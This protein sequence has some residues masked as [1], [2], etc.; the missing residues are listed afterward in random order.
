MYLYFFA[1]TEREFDVKQEHVYIESD[2]VDHRDVNEGSHQTDEE[3]VH[4]GDE[5]ALVEIS[6][7]NIIE[8]FTDTQM[9]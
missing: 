8:I 1:L 7:R 6:F 4:S 2:E 9:S 3:A 5:V